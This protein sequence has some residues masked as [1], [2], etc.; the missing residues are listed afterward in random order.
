MVFSTDNSTSPKSKP[1]RESIPYGMKMDVNYV[2]PFPRLSSVL[3]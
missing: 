2:A 3:E 1:V